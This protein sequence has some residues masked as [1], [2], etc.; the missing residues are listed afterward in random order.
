M[1]RRL[2][3]EAREQLTRRQAALTGLSKHP[4]WPDFEAEIALKEE[5]IQKAVLARTLGAAP[6]D[7][8]NDLDI[9][10]WRGFI[11]GMRY[12]LAVPTGAEN[13][14]EQFLRS[15]GIQPEGVSVE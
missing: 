14:L 13:K 9:V 1:R 15:Q 4:S 3:P 2:T 11:Q 12:L 7:P 8:V 6:A 5:R 10:Y